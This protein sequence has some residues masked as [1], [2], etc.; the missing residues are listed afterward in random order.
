LVFGGIKVSWQIAVKIFIKKVNMQRDSKAV[1]N[2]A[3]LVKVA[4]VTICITMEGGLEGIGAMLI[5]MRELT[6]Q[7]LNDTYTTRQKRMIQLEICQ[8]IK[9]IDGHANRV[10]FN[11]MQLLNRSGVGRFFSRTVRPGIPDIPGGNQFGITVGGAPDK[12]TNIIHHDRVFSP[13]SGGYLE[14][15]ILLG[16]TVPGAGSSN[17]ATLRI[18]PGHHF[19]LVLNCTTP[20]VLGRYLISLVSPNGTI[21]GLHPGS[22]FD[23]DDFRV[24]Y[25]GLISV[26]MDTSYGHFRQQANLPL[27]EN[28]T[29][30]TDFYISNTTSDAV[31]YWTIMLD[32]LPD[33]ES[34]TFT[35]TIAID[36]S[37]DFV[38]SE[39]PTEAH[40]FR[41]PP[42]PK[43]WIQAGAN[44]NQGIQ[45]ST[46]DVRARTL[47]VRGLN[48]TTHDSANNALRAIDSALTQI[49][50]YR[51]TIGANM[52]RLEHTARSLLISS[53]NLQ[54]SESRIRNADMAREKKKFVMANILQQ[55]GVSMLA[56]A[57]QSKEIILRLLR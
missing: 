35:L 9:E 8:L 24:G 40:A 47:G 28:G 38:P 13:A 31:G 30:G 25:E 14:S 20:N 22:I 42:Y 39:P 41:F 32:N 33:S 49:N 7:A 19:A 34:S 45:F 18:P 6:I 53:E 2:H 5:R 17:F 23:P 21:F 55:A 4:E 50:G 51:A 15:M 29:Q 3:E 43:V 27:G 46:L 52:N 54:D 26:S 36:I 1:G 57:N 44:S 11:S 12:T 48:V 16:S 10:E 37:P 56:Q